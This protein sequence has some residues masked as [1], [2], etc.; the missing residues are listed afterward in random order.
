VLN[1]REVVSFTVLGLALACPAFPLPSF[2]MTAI[3]LSCR[4]S[5]KT[6]GLP[7]TQSRAYGCVVD[8]LDGPLNVRTFSGHRLRR[9]RS[10]FFWRTRILFFLILGADPLLCFFDSGRSSLEK[11]TERV[12]VL[13]ISSDDETR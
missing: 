7:G 3:P 12:E 6:V 5:R 13:M 8:F 9:V 2:A 10:V 11:P 1:S 4:E